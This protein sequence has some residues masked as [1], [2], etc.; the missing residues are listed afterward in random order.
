M[1]IQQPNALLVKAVLT[2]IGLKFSGPDSN[3]PGMPEGLSVLQINFVD[4]DSQLSWVLILFVHEDSATIHGYA[5]I[6]YV[7]DEKSR[8]Q[9]FAMMNLINYDYLSDAHLDYSIEGNAVRVRSVMKSPGLGVPASEFATWLN[10]HLSRGDYFR[11]IFEKI[12]LSTTDPMKALEN[13]RE[14]VRIELGLDSN[15]YIG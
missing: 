12:D 5:H 9:L 1:A 10:L 3:P 4:D 6:K 11:R 8:P 14:S 15:P 7:T 2:E 13:A